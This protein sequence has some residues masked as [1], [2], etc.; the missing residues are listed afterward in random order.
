VK[1]KPIYI[2]LIIIAVALI[3]IISISSS[4]EVNTTADLGNTPNDEVHNSIM[5]QGGEPNGSNVNSEIF[6]RMKKYEEQITQNPSD[7]TTMKEYAE[8]LFAAHKQE[9]AVELYEKILSADPNRIDILKMLSIIEFNNGNFIAAK[10]KIETILKLNPKDAEALYNMGVVETKVGD[11]QAARIQWE[12]LLKFHPNTKMSDMAKESL[13]RL[14]E[15][16]P[17]NK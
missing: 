14:A 6:D 9:K 11:I 8:L 5:Q 2:Y 3:T 16:N 15:N 12:N 4:D 7:T 17:Q 13:A 1:L 10:A